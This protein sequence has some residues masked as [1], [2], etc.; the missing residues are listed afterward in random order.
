MKVLL[1]GDNPAITGGVCNYTRP[2]FNHLSKDLNIQYLY[3]SS[4][5]NL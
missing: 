4:N 1:I 5:Q 2:I 3:S